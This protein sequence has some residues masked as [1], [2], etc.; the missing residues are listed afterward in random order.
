MATKSKLVRLSVGVEMVLETASLHA[1][2]AEVILPQK[3]VSKEVL[4]ART[5]EEV[6]VIHCVVGVLHARSIV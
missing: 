1:V 2:V 5:S 4:I 3:W 6:R